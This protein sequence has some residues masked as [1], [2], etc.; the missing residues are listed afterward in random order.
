MS[1]L[2][3]TY[4]NNKFSHLTGSEYAI[5]Y[6]GYSYISQ[7]SGRTYRC[8]TSITQHQFRS[9]DRLCRQ[10]MSHSTGS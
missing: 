5:G 2:S 1:N 3:T 7:T 6:N 9:Y 10:F 8:R 4:Y